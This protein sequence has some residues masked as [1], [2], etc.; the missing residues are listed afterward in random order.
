MSSLMWFILIFSVFSILSCKQT[1]L[2]CHHGWSQFGSRCFRIF[3]TATS[4]DDA[5]QNCVIMGGH[6]ASVHNKAEYMFI[7]ALVQNALNSNAQTWLGASDVQQ[8]GVWKWTDGS[9]FDYTNWAG[10]QPDNKNKME[11]CLMMNY[12]ACWN[13]AVCTCL[14]PSACAKAAIPAKTVSVLKLKIASKTNLLESDIEALVQQVKQ[15]LI[16]SGMPASATLRLQSIYNPC[17]C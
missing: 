1:S 13:D 17:K 7:Q 14:R 15:S 3:K 4:W 10:G 5:E 2:K 6:L 8:E 12:Q 16:D 11:N 9:A